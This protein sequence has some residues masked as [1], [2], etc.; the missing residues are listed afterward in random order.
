M[1]L[2]FRKSFGWGPFRATL[3]K[4]GVSFSAGVK[5][6]RITKKANGNIATS[7]GVPGTGVYHYKEYS[8]TKA[9]TKQPQYSKN[10][11]EQMA[12]SQIQSNPTEWHD[13]I[14][15]TSVD[16]KELFILCYYAGLMNGYTDGQ[17]VEVTVKDICVPFK[18]VDVN[19]IAAKNNLP[20]NCTSARLTTMVEKG[21]L[22]KEGRGIYKLNEQAIYPYLKQWVNIQE[23]EKERQ[24]RELETLQRFNA[25]QEEEARRIALEEQE[26]ELVYHNEARGIN[27]E[28]RADH[29]DIRRIIA[30][31]TCFFALGMYGVPSL[32]CK[33]Y[34][35][36]GISWA[37]MILIAL[38]CPNDTG[39]FIAFVV[40]CVIIPIIS[41]KNI[42]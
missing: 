3:S 7:L 16:E 21:W 26:R 30:I 31:I 38:T 12:L 37:V 15:F 23:Q 40:C 28:K 24:Q 36:F 34:K 20:R 41:I 2:R 39:A 27:M 9:Q 19:N 29:K 5:G 14:P 11:V 1:G 8:N 10:Q 18:I 33:Q 42:K 17:V 22:V 6:A 25:K 13:L 32:L 4:S 35:L